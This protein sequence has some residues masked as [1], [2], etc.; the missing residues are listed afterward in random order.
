MRR[1]RRRGG[2]G[3]R[4]RGRGG[5]RGRGGDKKAMRMGGSSGLAWAKDSRGGSAKRAKPKRARS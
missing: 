3:G 4:R 1:K 2:G 5:V